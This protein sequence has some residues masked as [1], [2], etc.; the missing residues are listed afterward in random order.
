MIPMK[1]LQT[2]AVWDDKDLPAVA[3]GEVV[4]LAGM[5]VHD[6]EVNPAGETGRKLERGCGEPI[7]S[8]QIHVR[9]SK[10]PDDPRAY[11]TTSRKAHFVG[12]GHVPMHDVRAVRAEKSQQAV[13]R[14]DE[15]VT[16]FLVQ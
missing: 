8:I 2:D 12:H 5:R 11:R 13:A 1:S 16:I 3:L 4:S 7:V 10:T 6:E 14:S 9:G 15:V